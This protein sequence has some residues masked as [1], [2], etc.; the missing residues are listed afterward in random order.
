MAT[1]SSSRTKVP[2]HNLCLGFLFLIGAVGFA[3]ADCP[4]G[5]RAGGAPAPRYDHAVAYD[6][7]RNVLVLFGGS[8]STLLPV[9][10]VFG[11][12]WEYDGSR[13]QRRDVPGPSPRHSHVMAYDSARHVVVLV[14]G[15]TVGSQPLFDTWEWNGVAWQQVAENFPT[16]GSVNES[17]MAFDA[18]RGVCVLFGGEYSPDRATYLWDGLNWQTVT[19]AAGPARRDRHAMTYDSVRQRIV[20]FGG[21][22][23]PSQ[24]TNETWEWDGASWSLRS[25]SGPTPRGELGLAFDPTHNETVLFGGFSSAPPNPPGEVADTWAW[26]GQTW[27]ERIAPSVPARQSLAMAYAP[28]AGGVLL[29]GGTDQVPG[30]LVALGDQWNWNGDA[31]FSPQLLPPAQNIPLLAFDSGR[32]AMVLVEGDRDVPD[33]D[34]TWE[35]RGVAW[36][37]RS[38]FAPG[39]DFVGTVMAF[40]PDAG[41]TLLVASNRFQT[42]IGETWAWNG[43]YWALLNDSLTQWNANFPTAMAFDESQHRIMM[44]SPMGT[45]AWTGASWLR[46]T[47]S[48]PGTTFMGM[49]FDRNLNAMLLCAGSNTYRWNGTTWLQIATS[50]LLAAARSVV[51]DVYRYKGVLISDMSPP[52]GRTVHEW[53]GTHW[54]QVSTRGPDLREFG[55]GYDG[56]RQRTVLFGGRLMPQGTLTR[57]TWE[58]DGERWTL[59]LGNRPLG[60]SEH[61]AAFDAARHS[62]VIWGGRWSMASGAGYLAD[63]WEFDQTGWHIGPG[64]GPVGRVGAAMAFDE[65]RDV[66]VLVGGRQE[67]GQLPTDVWEWDGSVWEMI[68]PGQSTPGALPLA[69]LAY[70]P[71]IQR[72]VLWAPPRLWVWDGASWTSITPAASPDTPSADAL[73]TFDR[74]R[75]A[76]QAYSPTSRR[77]AEW[78]GDTWVARPALRTYCFVDS[79]VLPVRLLAPTPRAARD[80]D[81]HRFAERLRVRRDRVVR[82]AVPGFPRCPQRMGGRIRFGPR[83]G[84]APRRP[85]PVDESEPVSR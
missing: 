62:L 21:R 61:A 31:W 63:T 55:L 9:D 72:V 39:S 12:T 56:S 71:D 30:G 75:G 82:G 78:V 35:R 77:L 73:L 64:Y 46:L 41:H 85:R 40:D 13:W 11:D 3:R 20:L 60:R 36:S 84:R 70:D 57:D 23:T 8:D 1:S 58:W 79:P 14:G 49:F 80:G 28:S 19:P 18:A 25:Q 68:V 50:P 69:S 48:A 52:N 37:N 47:T 6:S 26:D 83:R 24:Y 59:V 17:A 38:S 34:S 15:S 42:S 51:F 66:T 67:N 32:Q 27:H 2:R 43:S 33:F 81:H 16:G 76:I 22:I 4:A 7:Q 5:W 45:F 53:D 65:S 54:T 44:V 10:S 29:F 74:D